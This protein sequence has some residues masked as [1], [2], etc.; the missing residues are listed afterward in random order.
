MKYRG[1][2]KREMSLTAIRT[3]AKKGEFSKVFIKRACVIGVGDYSG[4]KI[5]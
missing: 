3:D 2:K 5:L 4:E 1:N